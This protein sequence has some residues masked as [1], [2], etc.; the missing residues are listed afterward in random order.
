MI[1]HHLAP[2]SRRS[3][4]EDAAHPAFRPIVTPWRKALGDNAD[5]RYHD[6]KVDPGG[7]YRVAGPHGGA[8]Y[9]SFTVEAGGRGRCV[10]D[11]APSGC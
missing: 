1:L 7:T 8:V 6:A 9:V 10:P 5:A 3:S 2:A 11:R 4:S